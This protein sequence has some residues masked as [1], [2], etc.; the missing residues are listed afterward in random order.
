MGRPTKT[1]DDRPFSQRVIDQVA[2]N[3]GVDPLALPPLYETLDPEVLDALI[4][5]H[6][7]RTDGGLSVNFTYQNY[8]VHVRGDGSVDV[9]PGVAGGPMDSACAR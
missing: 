9:E 7:D 5:S 6:S 8:S 1:T 3:E 4:E 2:A